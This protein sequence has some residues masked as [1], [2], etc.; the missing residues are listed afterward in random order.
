MRKE[1]SGS[2]SSWRGTIEGGDDRRPGP[3][4]AATSMRN[5]LLAAILTT[6]ALGCSDAQED[7]PR[8][9][10]KVM[11]RNLFLGG[12]FGTNFNDTM[13]TAAEIP[14]RVA[15]FWTL[16]TASDIPGR[17]E[18]LA[19]EIVAAQADLVGLQELEMFRTHMPSDFSFAAAV[20]NAA[21]TRFDFLALLRNALAARGASYDVAAETPFT[22]VEFPGA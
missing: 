16:V 9:E 15:Q 11:T 2:C 10:L 5:K 6:A 22:D 1:T 4:H 20:T 8:A 12:E 3:R 17:I 18:L 7:G 14:A 21:D 13:L 19:D